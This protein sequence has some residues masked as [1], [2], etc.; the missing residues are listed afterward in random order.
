VQLTQYGAAAAEAGACIAA[1]VRLK[2]PHGLF[3]AG[4]I[5]FEAAKLRSGVDATGYVR[6]VRDEHCVVGIAALRWWPARTIA[7]ARTAIRTAVIT[8]FDNNVSA[9]LVLAL[10]LGDYSL[11]DRKQWALFN[12]TGT[13][14]LVT[15]S[16]LHIGIAATLGFGLGNLLCLPL[17]SRGA[18][19][20]QF[21]AFCAW[22]MALVYVLLAGGSTPALRSLLMLSLFLLMRLLRRE[23]SLGVT[24]WMAFVAIVIADPLQATSIGFWL[25]F[26]AVSVLVV[27]LQWRRQRYRFISDL[28]APQWVVFVGLAPLLLACF[29]QLP[30]V[31]T[32]ANLLAVP[33]SSFAVMPL[34]LFSM[35]CGFAVPLL[36]TLVA[37]TLE[38]LCLWLM[39]CRNL[40]VAA[41]Q[42]PAVAPIASMLAL[43][44]AAIFFLLPRG[45]W[46]RPQAL[47]L[48]GVLLLAGGD[49]APLPELTLD[50]FDVGQGL[51][52]L[53]SQGDHHLLF[54]T[55]A[56]WGDDFDAAQM[57]VL[58]FLRSRGISALDILM[59]SHADMDHAGGVRSVLDAV[60]V[61]SIFSGE[62]IAS[63]PLASR[64]N[65]G[66]HWQ[67]GDARLQVLF[68]IETEI[69]TVAPMRHKRLGNNASCVLLIEFRG[70]RLLLTGDIEAAGE[71]TLLAAAAPELAAGVDV[72]V[73]PHHGSHSSS[74]PAFVRRLHPAHVVFAVGYRNRFGHPHADVV[75]RYRGVGSIIYRSDLDGMIRF[76]VGADG[77]LQA[78]RWRECWPHYWFL[79]S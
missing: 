63:A 23:S 45:L 30:L 12:A 67:L 60:Q 25:S 31:S 62:P 21:A 71:Q 3:N 49:A 1:T 19:R 36:N 50:V 61:G 59:V 37:A 20:Q 53:V 42:L 68:P 66:Q 70:R 77:D 2:R 57:A 48:V 4:S 32:L 55:G 64:C 78:I 22:L 7:I 6:A 10:V 17:R 69:A 27:G 39:W 13:Q 46:L 54:D 29:G 72:L 18:R 5:D 44:L 16:G 76:H 40:P 65:R 74:T 14:H 58:P 52:V 9:G 75:E 47:V 56:A 33:W 8:H 38:Y 41:L 35:L 15:V 43:T 51:A 34:L 28:V 73:A 11:V 24:L 26:G 79:E